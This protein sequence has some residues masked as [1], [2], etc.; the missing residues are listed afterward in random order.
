MGTGGAKDAGAAGAAG[1]K[2]ASTPGL[3]FSIA[4]S[5]PVVLV[6]GG[7][8][9]ITVNVTRTTDQGAITLS[10][11]SLP[12]GVTTGGATIAAGSNQ[13]T[14]T[15]NAAASA[16]QTGG[17]TI[18]VH[19][20]G[21]SG[22]TDANAMLQIKGPSGSLDTT[23]GAGGFAAINVVFAVNAR[24]SVGP[25]GVVVAGQTASTYLVAG[26][27]RTAA[28]NTA[29]GTAGSVS[30]GSLTNG[31]TAT[32]VPPR[33]DAN[34][35]WVMR[36]NG[37]GKN[38]AVRLTAAG[39][40]DTTFSG[41]GIL[42]FAARMGNYGG[43][44]PLS[45]G[46]YLAGTGSSAPMATSTAMN[47]KLDDQGNT[48]GSDDTSKML[49]DGVPA[50]SGQTAKGVMQATGGDVLCS[51]SAAGDTPLC[52]YLP[53]GIGAST[54]V[55]IEPGRANRTVA[56][57]ATSTATLLQFSDISIDTT[58]AGGRRDV[59]V[60]NGSS[61]NLQ[62][63]SVVEVN[64]KEEI[65][66]LGDAALGA[67]RHMFVA[68][69]DEAG[70]YVTTFGTNGFSIVDFPNLDKEV[71]IQVWPEGDGVYLL[72]LSTDNGESA[73]LKGKLHAARLWR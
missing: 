12:A 64:F 61:P 65:Y 62:G 36:Y 23:F 43:I 63:L 37:L 38:A 30:F 13:G 33:L 9:G 70:N 53:T 31:Q 1:S 71:G 3:G 24:A 41:D 47:R 57:F 17:V 50:L 51:L 27:T 34:G 46:G 44:V 56:A 6:Q 22:S 35:R 14:L 72:F 11:T 55:R 68:K 28:L 67:T 54:V 21:A 45:G 5:G 16:V 32:A 48:V 2:D 52:G 15:L 26:L 60:P 4:A 29:F 39:A 59:A 69:L 40:V 42:D 73:S 49:M 66:V 10:A 18:G 7:S 19:A 20:V 8:V 25:N 58:F